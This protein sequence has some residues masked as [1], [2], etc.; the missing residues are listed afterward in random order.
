MSPVMA[1]VLPSAASSARRAPAFT[2]VDTHISTLGPG[3]TVSTK[4]A[5]TNN[6]QV[7]QVMR[8]IR[9]K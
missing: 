5:A 9:T 3:V 8:R 4:T 7:D 2:E 6:S 1:V